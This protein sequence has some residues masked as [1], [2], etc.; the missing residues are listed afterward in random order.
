[1]AKH[2][3]AKRKQIH[4]LYCTWL[5]MRRRCRSKN[6]PDFHNYGGRG[7]SICDRWL[8]GTDSLSAFECFLADVGPK[9]TPQHTLDRRD[10]NGNYAP[11]NCRWAT[12]SEQA[13][14]QRRRPRELSAE[15]VRFIRKRGR[16]GEGAAA[17]ARSI[18]ISTNHASRIIRGLACT[19][20]PDE[21]PR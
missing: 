3:H 2:G 4:P 17:I 7:I 12:R 11:D 10:N 18:G 1:M 13:L 21:V 9:P 20:V 19:M 15:Q 8:N 16:E 14:N 5:L 6:H